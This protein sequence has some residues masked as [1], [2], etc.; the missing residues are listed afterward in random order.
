MEDNVISLIEYKAKKRWEQEDE[1]LRREFYEIE[2]RWDFEGHYRYGWG[3]DEE[4]G[5]K[6]KGTP[7]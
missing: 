2:N 5:Q 6:E 3:V 1:E 7:F 4:G